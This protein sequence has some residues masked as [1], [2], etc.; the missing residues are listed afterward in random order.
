M[1]K[2]GIMVAAFAAD[3]RLYRIYISPTQWDTEIPNSEFIIPN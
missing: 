2:F 3:F 1:R